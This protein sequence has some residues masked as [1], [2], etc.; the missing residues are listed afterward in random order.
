MQEWLLTILAQSPLYAGLIIGFLLGCILWIFSSIF[1]RKSYRKQKEF[2][3]KKYTN[4]QTELMLLKSQKEQEQKFF[5]E[6]VKLLEDSRQ[7]ML[8]QFKELS[9]LTL[10]EN[11]H[12]FSQMQQ[13][14]LQL[15]LNPLSEKINY[16][17]KQVADVY[18]K[19]MRERVSLKSHIE[20]INQ[21]SHHLGEEAQKL[22][23]ALKA[24]SK[25]Q[26]QWGEVVLEG[27]LE[28][29][30]L[31]KDTH[32]KS[33]YATQNADGQRVILD[34]LLNLPENRQIIIDA[35]V[36][37]RSWMAYKE[38]T[39]ADEQAKAYSKLEKAISH[40]VNELSQKAYER[41]PMI[42][43]L[44]CVLM[45]IPQEAAL[46]LINE[47]NPDFFTKALKKNIMLVT[48]SSLMLSLRIIQHLWKLNQ[49]DKFSRQILIEAQ[50]LHRK[51]VIFAEHL[52]RVKNALN[53]ADKAYDAAMASLEGRGGIF[54]KIR[55][56]ED[57]GAVSEKEVGEK[58][59]H[60]IEASLP[61]EV[62]SED[63]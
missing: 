17:Q 47:N 31:I 55:K 20:H 4:A 29:V 27:I 40:H 56:L 36:S 59:L 28:N 30:G 57:M 11:A 15:L 7:T 1:Q 43:T 54:S 5:D 53:T 23:Q 34:I 3:Q 8:L 52:N 16:F 37:L 50:S 45:F 21:T 24:Q 32:Y 6:K 26:G 10:K 41:L 42:E 38:A 13:K 2:L 58:I 33:Q 44:D 60:Q 49:Q 39:N 46:A 63:G 61:K 51:F 62:N 22:S 35:K 19:E 12:D 18:D 9:S 48:P 14:Q 25:T